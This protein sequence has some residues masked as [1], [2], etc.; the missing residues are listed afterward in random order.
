MK[1]IAIVGSRNFNN[2][3]FFKDFINAYL[4]ENPNVAVHFVS[5][6]AV[7][8]DSMAEKYAQEERIPI[9]IFYPDW[10]TFGR[11]AGRMR[12]QEIVDSADELI[13]F[14]DGISPGTK[15]S[16]AFAKKKGIPYKVVKIDGMLI[17]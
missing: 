11:K 12:N 14:W 1:K 10:E 17:Y 15:T 9:E 6:G 13:A 7:G 2:Y 4:D 8:T 3:E 5:G 16:I